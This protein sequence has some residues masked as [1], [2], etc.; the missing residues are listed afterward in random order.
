L[1]IKLIIQKFA[2]SW[3]QFTISS[4]FRIASPAILMLAANISREAHLP[5]GKAGMALVLAFDQSGAS[6]MG[7][8]H[9][10]AIE[11]DTAL[12]RISRR[13]FLVW[14]AHVAVGMAV[15]ASNCLVVAAV[16]QKPAQ[17]KGY[18]AGAYG[19]GAFSGPSAYTIYLPAVAKGENEHGALT[20]ARQ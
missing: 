1:S 3:Q 14:G 18:G 13:T 11:T 15:L 4:R 9:A 10:T 6:K 12:P 20:G 2:A 16:E 8:N 17:M 19:H 7:T 5:N